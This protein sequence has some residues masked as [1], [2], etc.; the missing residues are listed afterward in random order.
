MLCKEILSLCLGECESGRAQSHCSLV[1]RSD[2][3]LSAGMVCGSCEEHLSM[4]LHTAL[5]ALVSST[6]LG[7]VGDSTNRSSS[8]PE[9]KA[10]SEASQCGLTMKLEHLERVSSWAEREILSELSYINVP[11]MFLHLILAE[12]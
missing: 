2:L 8:S 9:A 11:A 4:C 6:G 1:M 5:L 7:V 10:F 12:K 3:E